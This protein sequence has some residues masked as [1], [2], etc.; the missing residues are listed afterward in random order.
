V[1]WLIALVVLLQTLAQWL[2]QP[3][4]RGAT[5]VFGLQLL[6]WML[7]LVGLWLLAG[8]SRQE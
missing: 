5:S 1:L 3:A 7:A 4:I 8:R 2:I 6:P